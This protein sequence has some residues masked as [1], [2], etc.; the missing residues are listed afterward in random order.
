MFNRAHDTCLYTLSIQGCQMVYFQTKNTNLGTLWRVL[1]WEMLLYFKII[2]SIL[3]PFCIIYGS[4]VK[5]VV[6]WYIFTILV[7]LDQ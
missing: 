7:R 4:L 5:L 6:I 2:W 3:W 1:E